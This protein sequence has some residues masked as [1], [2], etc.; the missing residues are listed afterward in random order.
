MNDDDKMTREALV[1]AAS[2]SSHTLQ[3]YALHSTL[4]ND[5]YHY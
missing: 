2:V 4:W 3:S 1:L 5:W